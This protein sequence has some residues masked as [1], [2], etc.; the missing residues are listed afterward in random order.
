MRCLIL[1]GGLGTRLGELFRET[2]K[3]LIDI[4]GK[5]FLHHQLSFLR[6]QGITE[7]VLAIGHHGEQIR[8]FIGDGSAWGLKAS[9][10]DEGKHLLGT[11][12][13]LRKSVDS[14]LLGDV[15]FL[16]Y[17]DVI[18]PVDFRKAWDSFRPASFDALMV[19][20]KNADRNEPSNVV[21]NDGKKI[22][23]YDKKAK[24]R[25]A[26]M[27][28]IDYGLSL[29]RADTVRAEIPAGEVYDLA[30][31]VHRLSLEGRLQG[32]AAELP[33]FEIGSLSG[34]ETFR[35]SVAAAKLTD[36]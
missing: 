9:F 20:Y 2:P 3:A 13:A 1:A 4:C 24:S 7:V 34:L 11:G 19:V 23:L 14:G 15:F 35:D 27:Q 10:V 33:V 25:P 32:F 17:G 16:T 21:F 30:Q 18:T 26:D 29:F 12:G 5:P 31:F 36:F 28:W 8:D 22:A 6:S